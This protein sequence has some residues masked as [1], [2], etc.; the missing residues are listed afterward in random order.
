[1]IRST[2]MHG[3]RTY[4]P[5]EDM[6][7]RGPGVEC[8]MRAMCCASAGQN[9]SSHCVTQSVMHWQMISREGASGGPSAP[10]SDIR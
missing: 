10:K 1:M 3:G 5:A 8:S 6:A 9:V 2:K 4:E 7:H